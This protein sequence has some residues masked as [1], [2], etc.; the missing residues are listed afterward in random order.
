MRRELYFSVM[1]DRK[2]N[3]PVIVASTRGGT[4]IED[5][6]HHTPEAIIK[7]RRRAITRWECVFVMPNICIDEYHS[8][9]WPRRMID[10]HGT[11]CTGFIRRSNTSPDTTSFLLAMLVIRYSSIP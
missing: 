3:G 5:V 4:S 2:S 10:Y 6:A 11:T 1:L 9:L 8:T 7:V